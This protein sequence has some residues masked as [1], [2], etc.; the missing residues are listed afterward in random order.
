[1]A[2]SEE[3]LYAAIDRAEN[4]ARRWERVA[5]EAEAQRNLAL[6]GKR[7]AEAQVAAEQ[8]RVLEQARE[9]VASLDELAATV[10]A[11]F[12]VSL[13]PRGCPEED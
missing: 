9:M 11:R 8:A 12:G 6:A 5:V 2:T 10:A 1:M 13:P 3:T 7:A 4:D